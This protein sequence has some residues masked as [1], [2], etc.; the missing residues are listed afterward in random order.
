MRNPDYGKLQENH[1]TAWAPDITKR[2]LRIAWGDPAHEEG[3]LAVLRGIDER[4]RLERSHTAR[5]GT[6]GEEAGVLV[7]GITGSLFVDEFWAPTPRH[8]RSFLKH[9]STRSRS[10]ALAD[11]HTDSLTAKRVFHKDPYYIDRQKLLWEEKLEIMRRRGKGPPKKGEGKRA[12]RK[13]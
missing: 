7:P 4:A 6:Q 1:Q 2:H 11:W 9:L 8:R 5:L 3:D 13:K 10:E 12:T